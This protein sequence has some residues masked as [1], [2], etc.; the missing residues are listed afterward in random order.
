MRCNC[1]T[2]NDFK[3]KN[4]STTKITDKYICWIHLNKLYLFKA[5]IIQ[6]FWRG[7]KCRRLLKNIFINLPRDLQ[8]KI[9]FYIREPLLIEKYQHTTIRK[10]LTNRLNTSDFN[11]RPVG[12]NGI[13]ALF[14]SSLNLTEVKNNIRPV[15]ELYRLYSK[16]ITI[17][18]EDKIT[19]L[20]EQSNVLM[21]FSDIYFYQSDNNHE[22]W[23]FLN[24][25]LHTFRSLARLNEQ[26][27][28]LKTWF[29]VYNKLL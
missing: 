17:A 3:C 24:H 18:E 28:K 15:I 29:S 27:R 20:L 11:T 26:I 23:R 9:V 4:K 22:M 25:N 12:L 21:H 10:I 13:I 2:L 16:Y 7:Y 6:K 5:L 1:I 19:W 14:D 8:R